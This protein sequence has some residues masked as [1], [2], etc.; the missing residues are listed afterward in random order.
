MTAKLGGTDSSEP[1]SVH[2]ACEGRVQKIL[3][4]VAQGAVYTMRD[5]AEHVRLSPSHMQRL[6]KQ[7]TGARLGEWLTELRL[8]RAAHLLR[9]SYLSVKEITHAVGYEHVS[10]F[11]RAFERR[12]GNS[13]TAYRKGWRS[14]PAD[15]HVVSP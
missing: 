8:Q 3:E 4:L 13:P 15:V 10:S 2:A 11:T 12:F 1:R 7:E 14:P 5:L 6:F 9:D